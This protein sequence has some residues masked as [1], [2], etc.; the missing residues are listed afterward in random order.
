MTDGLGRAKKHKRDVEDVWLARRLQSGRRESGAW[1]GPGTMLCRRPR[2][3]ALLGPSATPTDGHWRAAGRRRRPCFLAR[4][5]RP[6]R[7]SRRPSPSHFACLAA[8]S[9]APLFP[10]S[11]ALLHALRLTLPPRV[12]PST[13]TRAKR[14]ASHVAVPSVRRPH[15]SPPP[16]PPAPSFLAQ[17]SARAG[18]CSRDGGQIHR[19]AL[20]APDITRLG[21]PWAVA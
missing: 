17:R 21:L 5:R 12:R 7:R 15:P 19:L 14:C 4:P 20:R 6:S 8:V 11:S 2:A 1:R 3:P 16:L 9:L 13:H 10:I 18:R